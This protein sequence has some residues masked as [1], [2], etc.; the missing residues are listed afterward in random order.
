MQ[1]QGYICN[2]EKLL[3]PFCKKFCFR[4]QIQLC[5][6]PF[7]KYASNLQT[8]RRH[9]IAAAAESRRGLALCCLGA[10]SCRLH[11][12][13]QVST[14]APP[15]SLALLFNATPHRTFHCR[16]PPQ[17]PPPCRRIPPK[18]SGEPI[19]SSSSLSHPLLPI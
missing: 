6:G 16:R 9:Y 8:P 10:L 3:A 11:A 1:S 5:K 19:S 14:P 12:S 7:C 4:K 13:P 15:P 18:A 2:Y 17:I